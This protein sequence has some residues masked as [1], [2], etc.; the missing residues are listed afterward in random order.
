MRRRGP[1]ARLAA[2]RLVKPL[3]LRQHRRH[4][5]QRHHVRA[6]GRCVV[7]ILVAFHEQATDPDRNSG[8]CQYRHKF[9]LPA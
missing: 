1:A 8:T 5:I 9:T 4:G 7:R 6:V 3:E 2:A